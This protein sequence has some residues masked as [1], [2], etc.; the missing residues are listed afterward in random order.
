MIELFKTVLVLSLLGFGLTALL[1]ALKPFTTRRFPAKWQ[2][3]V[4]IAVLILMILPIYKFIPKQEAQRLS[5]VAMGTV[6]QQEGAPKTDVMTQSAQP[7]QSLSSSGS[8]EIVSVKQSFADMT[9]IFAYIWIFGMCLYLAIV[10]ISYLVYLARK[11]KNSFVITDNELFETA[12]GE[13]N[14][15]RNIRLKMCSD[16]GSPMLV[17][18]IFPTVYLP[19]KEICD[20]S[21]RMVFLHELTHYKRGDLVIKWLSLFVNAV[22][23]FNPLAY[24]LCANVGEACEISCDMAVTRNM[25]SDEQK[26]YMKTILD[27]VE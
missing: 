8:D 15:R 17:G 3:L 18:V 7:E 24:I 21:L 1:L 11:R 23:W 27:L 13:L 19:A 5:Y 14:I 25:N 9:D 6:V 20:E 10:M 26:N 22:H 2:Y 12:K 4:W 16:M